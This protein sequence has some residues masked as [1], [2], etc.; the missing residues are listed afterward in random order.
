MRKVDYKEQVYRLGIPIRVREIEEEVQAYH[1][2]YPDLFLSDTPPQLLRPELKNGASSNGN[3][4]AAPT[5]EKKHDSGYSKSV[6]EKR[7]KSLDLLK[8]IGQRPRTL[9]AMRKHGVDMRGIHQLEHNGY[10][11]VTNDV[12]RR[13][14]KPFLVAKWLS[15]KAAANV[16]ADVNKNG[17]RTGHYTS[18]RHARRTQSAAFLDGFDTQTPKA[19]SSQGSKST[20]SFV[21]RGYL[22]HHGDGL[23]TRTSKV[24]EIDA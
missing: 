18:K 21:R 15:P 23:Y 13:T 10:V 11:K 17:A 4:L 8:W 5:T 7:T 19:P 14:N 22:K 6:I 1:R 9:E 16:M 20:G 24:Y 2:D 12:F 3:H